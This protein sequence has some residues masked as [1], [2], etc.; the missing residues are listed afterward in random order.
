MIEFIFE[1]GINLIETFISVDF[2][3]RYLGAKYTGNRQKVAF[4]IVWIISFIQM[5]VTNYITDFETF[6]SYI[7]MIIYACY[8]F[9]G[10]NGSIPQKIWF[11]ILTHLI[12]VFTAI[13]TNILLCNIIGYDPYKMITVFNITRVMGVIMAKIM[14]FYITRLILRNKYKNPISNYRWVAI[15]A[16]PVISVISICSLMKAALINND[17]SPYIL[18]GMI[19]IILAN[20]MTYYFFVV[21]N[22]EYENTIKSKLLEQQNETLKRSIS[23][24]EAFVNEMKTVRHDIKNQLLT[25]MKYA[26]EGKNEDIK[27]Y[28]SVLTN[29]YLPNILN[30]INT[31]NAAFDAVINSKIAVCSQRNIFMEVN[32][33]QNTDMFIL[34]S[35]IA[36]LFGN[37][38]DNA[39]EAAKDT[40]E[41]RITIDIQKNASYLIIFVSNSIKSSVLKD[42]KNLETSKPDK[43][44]HGIGI[45]S[46]KNI[47]EKHNGMI[48]FYEEENEFCCHIMIDTTE[49]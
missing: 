1:T 3:T 44:L 9:L 36:V 24:K 12:V 14:Q 19:C 21:M 17:T 4:V 33:K 49:E 6:G 48:Q 29:N 41:K 7:P 42:N 43:E 8:A 28:V 10:L 32:I 16:I 18:T 47:V 27:E 20:V 26:D 45:K 15:I 31:N 22:K 5:T 46:I 13:L 11:A 25:I 40:D 37:L 38:L 23:D 35:E 2:I 39:I 34:P 30:Y